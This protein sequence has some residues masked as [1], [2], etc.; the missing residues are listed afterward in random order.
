[1]KDLKT[2]TNARTEDKLHD[3]DRAQS[4]GGR[5]TEEMKMAG[6]KRFDDCNSKDVVGILVGAAQKAAEEY[7]LEI[8]V[9]GRLDFS[10]ADL[11][12]RVCATTPGAARADYLEYAEFRGLPKDGL[13]KTFRNGRHM[14]KISGLKPHYKFEVVTTLGDGRRYDWRLADVVR[15]MKWRRTAAKR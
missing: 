11:I 4:S 6:I 10:R 9:Q 5:Q 2:M 8:T 14:Y 1:V 15:L 12:F 7:G 3:P 13:G